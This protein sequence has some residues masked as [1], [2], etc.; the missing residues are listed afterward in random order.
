M[1]LQSRPPALTVAIRRSGNLLALMSRE[2]PRLRRLQRGLFRLSQWIEYLPL[3]QASYCYFRNRL[4]STMELLTDGD[5]PVAR[6]Q[7]RE[8]HAKLQRLA[9]CERFRLTAASRQRIA[10]RRSRPRPRSIL[11]ICWK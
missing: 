5:L 7:L 10:G 9:S 11:K 3:D 6:Y 4:L 8:M 1:L 2:P